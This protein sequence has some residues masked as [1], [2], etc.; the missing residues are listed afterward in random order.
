MNELQQIKKDIA[1]LKDNIV[2]KDTVIMVADKVEEELMRRD[3][4]MDKK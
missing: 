2:D 3:V 4:F 1:L